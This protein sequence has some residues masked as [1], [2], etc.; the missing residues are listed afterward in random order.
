MEFFIA[1][2]AE[3]FQRADHAQRVLRDAVQHQDFVEIRVLR[4]R[5]SYYDE[6]QY[7]GVSQP[8]RVDVE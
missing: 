2:F 1:D 6:A 3:L 7:A 4:D 5:L 8:D